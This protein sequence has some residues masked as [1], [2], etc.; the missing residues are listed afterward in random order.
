MSLSSQHYIGYRGLELCADVGGDPAKPSV[1]LLH[2]GGQTRHSWGRA[3]RALVQSGHH[4]LAM[5]LR[6]HGDSGWAADGDYSINAFVYDLKAV[7]GTL[8]QPPVLVGASLGGA[9]ALLCVGESAEPLASALVLVDVV[10]RMSSDGIKHIGDFMQGNLDGFATLDDAADAVTRYLPNRKRPSSS[11]GLLKN[12][13]LTPDG[14]Y[15]WHWDPQFQVGKSR[16]RP[17]EMFDRMEQA[18][19]HIKIPTLLV[20]GKESEV[21]SPEGAQLLLDLIPHAQQVDVAGAGHM[22]AG[23]KNDAFNSAIEAFLNRSFQTA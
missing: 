11:E 3:A 21:V 8:E 17:Q 7:I 13:R 16:G 1:I 23:D 4:V 5:D 2:G 6:G 19:R 15:Y 9:T 14:R 18:A 12:L 20:R 22:V 10:P